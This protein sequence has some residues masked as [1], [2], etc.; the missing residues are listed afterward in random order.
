MH[1]IRGLRR[2][3]ENENAHRGCFHDC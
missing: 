1:Q 2:A 3:S